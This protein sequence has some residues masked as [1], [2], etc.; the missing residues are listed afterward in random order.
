MNSLRKLTSLLSLTLLLLSPLPAWSM[1]T[2][3]HQQLEKVMTMG[4]DELT[5]NARRLL[6]KKYPDENWQRY[7]FPAYVYTNRAVETG[8]KI[9][10]K[11][12][13]LLGRTGLT[14]PQQVIP[15][16]CFCDSLGHKNLLD[17]FLKG[18]KPKAEFVIHAA[19]CKI[20]YGQAMQAFLLHDLGVSHAEIVAGMEH[21]YQQLVEMHK[22]G[23]L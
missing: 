19:G 3:Q 8:Y 23:K 9:A 6:E 11:E 12:P 17:C 1:T 14:D 5:A 10:V 13:E 2:V 18:V 7:D 22:E 20:C 16:Y 15:C 4:M 21:R